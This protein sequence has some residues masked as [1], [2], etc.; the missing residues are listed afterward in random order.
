MPSKNKTARLAL[1]LWEP[2]DSPVR[3]D[4]NADNQAVDS[5]V[6]SLEAGLS[7]NTQDHAAIR[8]ELSARIDSVSAEALEHSF[9]SRSIALDAYAM[10][11]VNEVFMLEPHFFHAWK[12]DFTDL[13][14]IDIDGRPNASRYYVSDDKTDYDLPA[15]ANGYHP[16]YMD[17]GS[18]ATVSNIALPFT[19]NQRVTL[20][21]LICSTYYST[22]HDPADLPVTCKLFRATPSGS[23]YVLG[24]ELYSRT[25]DRDTTLVGS[26][27]T[28]EAR[29][30]FLDTRI[31]LEPGTYCAV[32][33]GKFFRLNTYGYWADPNHWNRAAPYNNAFLVTDG[34]TSQPLTMQ[35]D[36]YSDIAVRW[37]IVG[38]E[39]AHLFSV[40][41]DF[42]ENI[43]SAAVYVYA[44]K[45]DLELGCAILDPSD[46][47]SPLTVD[48]VL[49][50]SP[51][52]DGTFVTKLTGN[53]LY[54]FTRAVL[55]LD[56]YSPSIECRIR[57]ILFI[58]MRAEV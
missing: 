45:D 44:D 26:A 35:P 42:A 21:A 14:E 37:E 46:R 3:T 31:L 17:I 6:S 52:S 15:A 49:K 53:M 9:D 32:F 11:S 48:A 18:R 47:E 39:K 41:L 8:S 10:A 16:T 22:N 23:T 24:E 43:E 29:T 33:L 19:V 58:A 7:A 38:D 36:G 56:M 28:L 51:C 54:D 34:D 50:N 2:T 12:E 4:F 13:S 27:T 40:P 20:T 55:R 5:A 25:A 57:K 30:N 1:N